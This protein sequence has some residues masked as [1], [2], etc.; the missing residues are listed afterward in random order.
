MIKAGFVNHTMVCCPNCRA[1]RYAHLR[2]VPRED[3]VV[4]VRCRCEKCSIHFE[5]LEDKEGN[6]IR[7]AK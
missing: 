6:A 2:R 1:V 4:I 7:E 3:G 5:Y